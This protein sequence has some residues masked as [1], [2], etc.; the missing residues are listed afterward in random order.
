MLSP[1]VHDNLLCLL[2]FQVKIVFLAPRSQAA[3]L[4]PVDRVIIDASE[5]HRNLVICKLDE[6]VGCRCRC[7]IMGQ[8]C[9]E[10]GAQHTS[11]GGPCVQCHGAGSVAKDMHC[12]WSP[13]QKIQQPVAQGGVESQLKLFEDELWGMIVLNAELKS[14]NSTLTCQYFVYT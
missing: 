7:A 6:E 4:I 14:M 11:L 12:L 13:P 3:H 5:I 2:H 1:E 10:K 9:E 8:Q